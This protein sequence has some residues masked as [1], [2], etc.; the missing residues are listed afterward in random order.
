MQDTPMT[1]TSSADEPG[2]GSR[3]RASGDGQF[4]LGINYWPRRQAMYWWKSFDIGEVREEFGQIAALGATLVR[5][6]LLWED[7]QPAPDSVDTRQLNNLVRVLDA[8]GEHG[9]KAVPTLLVGNMSGVM[10]LPGWAFERRPE[11]SSALQISEGRYVDREAR[12]PFDDEGMLR[13]EDVLAEAAAG[14]TAGHPALHSWDLANEFDQVRAPRSPQSAWVWARLLTQTIQSVSGDILVTY[15]AHTLSLT[16]CGITIPA[17]ADSLDYLAMH[18]YPM[19]SPVAR[20]PLDP[21][22]TPFVTALTGE[23]GSMPVMMQEFGVCTAPPGEASQWIDDT[24]LGEVKRQFLAGEEDAAVYY[25]AVLDRLWQ[26]GAMGAVAWD[27][28]DYA[29]KLWDRPPLDLA[30]RERTFGL[31]R[32]DG[33][34]KP[35]AQVFCRF[36]RELA[37]GGL[38]ARLGPHGGRRPT[39]HVHPD[40]YYQDPERSFAA[41]YATYLAAL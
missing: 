39:L 36:A 33:S 24:F 25:A 17:L 3:L 18:G 1:D 10:W 32:S 29:P 22:F 40:T 34:L 28:A 15:G 6:F 20:G 2:R 21:E 13:A 37:T 26:I 4:L 11:Q 9:L 27:Y 31:V 38:E 23:L 5:F 14:V 8:A 35:A 19:Y 16:S 30:R 12:S 7:F 41:A